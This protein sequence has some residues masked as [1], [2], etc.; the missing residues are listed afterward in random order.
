MPGDL[1]KEPANLSPMPG[2]QNEF[3]RP[4]EFR[5]M[6]R[7]G[8]W[9]RIVNVSAVVVCTAS[10]AAALS[11]LFLIFGYMLFE[12][13]RY[14]NLDFFTRL[15]LDTPMGMR[16]SI[17]G[18]LILVGL[19]SA[20]GVPIGMLCGI[21]LVEY[22]RKGWSSDIV[23]I[24]LDVLAGTPTV[25]LGVLVYTVMVVHHHGKQLT[26]F[27]GTFLDIVQHVQAWV[28]I[29]RHYSGWAGGV[30]LAFIMVPIVARASE[31]M[32][33][34]VPRAHREASAALGASKAETLV[35]VVLPAAMSGIV[36]GILLAV[37]RVAGETAPLFFTSF[38]N[39][40]MTYN[41]SDQMDSLPERIYFYSQSSVPSQVHQSWA[42]ALVLVSMI[43]IF[44]AA[45]RFVTRKRRV[46]TH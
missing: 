10:A 31:E 25:L 19:A 14:L 26:G 45:M 6:G 43:T 8:L 16:N 3:R 35:R 34:L 36:T 15:P 27:M 46:K 42:A 39:T 28:G 32:L 40:A 44:S 23:R 7:S 24:V 17:V 18:T 12:G 29:P 9:R 22:A 30:A 37:A 5:A 13:V 33:R 20:A 2:G 21:Y 4:V 38:G 1:A 41:P 11:V